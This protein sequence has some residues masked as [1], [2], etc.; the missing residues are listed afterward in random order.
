M[1]RGPLTPSVPGTQPR[2]DRRRGR[3]RTI[4]RPAGAGSA[5]AL[6]FRT[7]PHRAGQRR[8]LPIGATERWLIVVIL[9]MAVGLGLSTG[10]FLTL[11]NIFDLANSSAVNIIFGVGLLVV[12]IA[13]G[14]D[15]SFT[16]AA[17]VVQY[18]VALAVGAIGGGELG[19]R[20]RAR[21]PVRRDARLGSTRS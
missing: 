21:G 4:R 1:P 13:G 6:R 20:L 9:A 17:S 14:I 16:V 5:A 2:A 3:R 19:D 7:T 15:I 11:P 12:L 8:T 18:L 10:T